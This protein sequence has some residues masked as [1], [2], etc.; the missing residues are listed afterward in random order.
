MI[1]GNTNVNRE[2]SRFRID[3]CQRV[4]STV[5]SKACRTKH[6]IQST[7]Q[8]LKQSLFTPF[9]GSSL[10]RKNN[11]G[12]LSKQSHA[13]VGGGIVDT[14]Q[15][16]PVRWCPSAA[17]RQTPRQGGLPKLSRAARRTAAVFIPLTS[18]THTRY[19]THWHA[20]STRKDSICCLPVTVFAASVASRSDHPGGF[21]TFKHD[22]IKKKTLTKINFVH[23]RTHAN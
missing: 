5:Q 13:W 10:N 22:E 12:T 15:F 23:L 16:N 11:C 20:T 19:A 1:I 21:T 3:P 2:L 6:F 4:K 17:S 8:S 14:A 7:G 18:I 9:Q